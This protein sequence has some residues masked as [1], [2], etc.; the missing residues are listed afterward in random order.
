KQ[1]PAYRR[2]LQ[3]AVL[4]M[5]PFPLEE[6]E[7]QFELGLHVTEHADELSAAFKFNKDL[8]AK[9]TIERMAASFLALLEDITEN[10]SERISRLSVLPAEERKRVL[11]LGQ[12]VKTEYPPLCVQE[13]FEQQAER[14]PD[15]IAVEQFG[16]ETKLTYRDL[17]GKANQLAVRLRALGVGPE[18][19]CGIHLER[20][21]ELV[22]AILAVLK[23]GGAYL[24]LDRSY[25][26]ERR[27]YMMQ[28]A[29]VPVLLTS[30]KLA[31]DFETDRPA[32]TICLDTEWESIATQPEANSL[33]KGDLNQ[34]A[35]VIYTSGSTGR[36]KGTLIT[37]RG[38]TNY[39]CWSLDAYEV[40]AGSGAPLNLAI[41]FDATITSL[42]PPLLTGGSVVLL[43]EE[44]GIEA[45]QKA[46]AAGRQFSLVKITPAHLE[47]L[48][49]M[50]RVGAFVR[51]A[52]RFVIGGEALR[53]DVVEQWR[54]YAP[55]IRLINEYG[56][57]ETV[58]GCCVYE[59]QHSIAGSVPIGR[60]IANTSLYVLDGNRNPVPLGVAGELYIGGAGVARGY[61]NQ[62]E[63]TESRFVPDLFAKESGARLYRTG[64]VV[65]YLPDGNL[66]FLG[67]ADAQMKIRGYRIEPGEIESVLTSHPLVREAAVVAVAGSDG[68]PFLAC[69]FVSN[70][71]A[72][73]GAELGAYLA[74]QL[75][76]YM[77][78]SVFIPMDAL[79]LT[80]NGKLDR[81]ALPRPVV[82]TAPAT[83]AAPRD[84]LEMQLA[85]IWEE[86][87]DTRPIGIKQNFFDLGGHSL[88]AVKLM[89]RIQQRFGAEISLSS[90]LRAPTIEQLANTMRQNLRPALRSSL[91]PMQ[92]AGNQLPFFCVPGAGGNAMY[93]YNLSR[94]LGKDQ[95]FYGLQG[96]GLDGE[97]APHTRVEEMAAHYLT[98][99]QSVQPHGPYCLGGHSLGGWVAFEMA[100]RLEEMGEEVA[101][102]AILDT[103][104][105]IVGE[106][107]DMSDWDNAQWIA[108]LTSKIGQLLNPD[109]RLAAEELR[110]LEFTAQLVRFRDALT[111]AELFPREAGVEHLEAV[112]QLFQA[113]SQVRY[114]AKGGINAG[115]TLLRTDGNTE[116]LPVPCRNATWGWSS[117][118][119]VDLHIVPGEH[120]SML[121]PPHVEALGAKLS[122]CLAQSRSKAA[123]AGAVRG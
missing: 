93:L 91:V 48:G 85:A 90:I 8:F 78:P 114:T 9:E 58:V 67:R 53:G 113:H 1:A 104:A 3:A 83:F 95:P 118:G 54:Q 115:I 89:A 19:I 66:E 32:K 105:P 76:E 6:E 110:G 116:E 98:A 106:G 31:S 22:I 100:Q 87:L 69:Y 80:A 30:S 79:P 82:Q 94:Q 63:L 27:A 37:H 18:V 10:P 62:P 42:F 108:E 117:L 24:P 64:D 75:P 52:N 99:I 56:P 16:T 17:N 57:T 25:P 55:D 11:A 46:L 74:K 88:L 111:G 84:S 39:L 102:L 15:A 65:R 112:L 68:S 29:A 86:V 73:A 33:N 7:G 35:Y 28:D 92:P 60:P 123:F 72:P 51:A 119:R 47:V 122:E 41:G 43:P 34:L 71:A 97:A 21:P 14:T 81:S 4:E 12:G 77:I 23:A 2:G 121:R 59:V 61:L 13:M 26:A 38:L 44:E 96:V 107:R 36:P 20:S 70:G 40:A 120:L 101:V 103:P 45:L 5:E 50:G 49:H 109:L